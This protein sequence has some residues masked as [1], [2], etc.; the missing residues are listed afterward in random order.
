MNLLSSLVSSTLVLLSQEV[1]MTYSHS[2]IQRAFS[3]SS[4]KSFHLQ[5]RKQQHAIF[6]SSYAS[7]GFHPRIRTSRPH[8]AFASTHTTFS[9][10]SS[11]KHKYSNASSTRILPKTQLSSSPMNIFHCSDSSNIYFHRLQTVTSPCNY[12]GTMSKTSNTSTISR[13]TQ[14]KVSSSD[15][16][17]KEGASSPNTIGTGTITIY[18]EQK[19]LPNIN[20]QTLEKTISTIRSI[21]G[22]PTYQVNLI[23]VDDE[24]MKEINLETRGIDKP[25]DILSFPLHDTKLG[26]AK[27]AGDLEEPEFDIPEYYSLGDMIV[28][29][30]YVMRRMEEDK[31]YYE[32]D[33]ETEN[34]I[35]HNEDEG[36]LDD[37][38]Y[39]D[40]VGDDDR[41]VSGAM[42]SVYD[43]EKRIQLLLIHGMLHLVGYDHIEDDDYE[44][45]VSKEEEVI[46]LLEELL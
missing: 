6:Q 26:G 15:D 20:I 46:K 14:L 19:T 31:L 25:T 4:S 21:I 11:A 23:L 29:V 7:I 44:V 12:F 38:E 22:Y 8:V 42:A 17:Y 13:N 27:G 3:L 28:D 35:D 40:Y 43:I 1:Q 2:S 36:E 37:D 41:G 10:T 32:N 16:N 9:T 34:D 18:N 39:E 45:M 33:D 5:Q 24:Y 30:P